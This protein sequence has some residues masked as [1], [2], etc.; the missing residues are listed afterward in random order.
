MR[1]RGRPFCNLR[2]PALLFPAL[3]VRVIAVANDGVQQRDQDGHGALDQKKRLDPK[4]SA[5]G[6]QPDE[7]RYRKG[8]GHEQPDVVEDSD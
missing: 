1:R 5:V 3:V 8:K 7:E 4:A 6:Q 2:T